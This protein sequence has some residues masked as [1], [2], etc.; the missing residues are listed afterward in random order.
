MT[1]CAQ[2]YILYKAGFDK[3]RICWR[4]LLDADS[5]R[6]AYRKWVAFVCMLGLRVYDRQNTTSKEFMEVG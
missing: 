2:M 4:V 5:T 3:M 6:L 1:K